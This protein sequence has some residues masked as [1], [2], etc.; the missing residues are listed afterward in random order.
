MEPVC[1]K[2]AGR[3][4]QGRGFAGACVLEFVC[5]CALGVRRGLEM[6]AAVKRGPGLYV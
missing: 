1:G 3:Q 6:W 4:G 5:V 2:A